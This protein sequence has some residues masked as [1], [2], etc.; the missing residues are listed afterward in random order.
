M[1]T[2]PE[3][4]EAF[5]I[6]R[7]REIDDLEAPLKQQLDALRAERDKLRRAA[8][9]IGFDY[10]ASPKP[11]KQDAGKKTSRLTLR[12][13]V[14]QTL[15]EAPQ[16]LTTINLLDALNAKFSKAYP[17]ASL[18]PE[19]S[20]MRAKNL[21]EL[22]GNLWLTLENRHSKENPDHPLFDQS[23][24]GLSV[25]DPEAQGVEAAPGGGT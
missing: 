4:L 20:R 23:V 8:M 5:I 7:R 19:L 15:R 9:A 21:V 24:S 1:A 16:G 3:S 12:E 17:K 6:Q 22:N 13:A 11:P 25:A 2:N 10:D 18:S 14:L